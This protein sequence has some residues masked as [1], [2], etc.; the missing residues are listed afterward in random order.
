M[1][2]ESIIYYQD[3]NQLYNYKIIN[4]TERETSACWTKIKHKCRT[5]P[6]FLLQLYL[7]PPLPPPRGVLLHYDLPLLTYIPL[8]HSV[9]SSFHSAASILFPE[10]F[11]KAYTMWVQTNGSTFWGLNLPSPVLYWD[12]FV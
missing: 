9:D 10:V 5:C 4:N 2:Y 12:Q 7:P 8:L 3:N 6:V 11:A 1:P